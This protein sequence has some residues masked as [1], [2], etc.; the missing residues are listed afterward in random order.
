MIEKETTSLEALGIAIRAEIDTAEIYNELSNRVS[1]E[2]LK[3]RLILLSKEEYKHKKILEEKY[4]ELFSDIDLFLPPSI[5]PKEIN[6]SDLREQISIIELLKYAIDE[7]KR[8]RQFY[9]ESAEKVDDLSGKQMFKYLADME[10]SH[11]MILSAE[12]ELLL[13]YP[14]YHINEREPWKAEFKK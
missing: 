6:S 4:K 13:K 5:L 14:Y 7:E 2:N 9:L 11:Q 12:Y 1:N 8:A 3:N 10:F